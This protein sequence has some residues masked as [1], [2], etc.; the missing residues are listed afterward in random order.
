M[1][2]KSPLEKVA[3][4]PRNTPHLSFGP[5][6]IRVCI[7]CSRWE[8]SGEASAPPADI[9]TWYCHGEELP[10]CQY[11]MRICTFESQRQLGCSIP[12]LWMFCSARNCFLLIPE[13]CIDLFGSVCR[14]IRHELHSSGAKSYGDHLS[15]SS[16]VSCRCYLRHAHV[17]IVSI[18]MN[19][20]NTRNNLPSGSAQYTNV[21]SNKRAC[22]VTLYLADINKSTADCLILDD[23]SCKL[24]LNVPFSGDS[25]SAAPTLIADLW[26]GLT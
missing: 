13:L 7:A 16:D 14:S 19:E 20:C 22:I 1:E 6:A 4:I 21:T 17:I 18:V 25:A 9:G 15:P 23:C 8:S 2:K 10:L 24:I 11:L 5:P 26:L 12:G 3:W